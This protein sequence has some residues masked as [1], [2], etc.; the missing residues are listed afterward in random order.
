MPTVRVPYKG[1]IFCDNQVEADAGDYVNI[2]IDTVKF[3]GATS[4]ISGR[5]VLISCPTEDDPSDTEKVYSIWI[6]EADL[7]SGVTTLHPSDITSIV[8]QTCCDTIQ[9]QVDDIQE[10]TDTNTAAISAL[11]AIAGKYRRIQ[12]SVTFT[13]NG[14]QQI[15][16]AHVD[17][18]GNPT[19]EQTTLQ[20]VDDNDTYSIVNNVLTG[21]DGTNDAIIVVSA[22]GGNLVS[23]GG[24]LGAFLGSTFTASLTFNGATHDVNGAMT[25]VGSF[26][27][28][29]GNV[30][31]FG[32]GTV[33]QAAHI[34]DASVAHGVSGSGDDAT[35]N[36][37]LDALGGKIN[38][39]IAIL[40]NLGFK[41]TS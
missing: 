2:T 31:F 15:I 25:L 34:T 14:S 12:P 32:A 41:A 6:D 18:L 35:I 38:S 27:H 11:Q 23:A 24:D 4:P 7:P 33:G 36:A 3:E 20:M 21:T 16:L 22:D 40:E 8:C 37:G 9:D 13:E 17:E 29:G 1:C 26:A 10:D 39:I 28:S 30:G 5:I 19:G